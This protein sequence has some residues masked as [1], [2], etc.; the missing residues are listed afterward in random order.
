LA[1]QTGGALGITE[2]T[3]DFGYFDRAEMEGLDVW[4]HQLQL[5]EDAFSGNTGAFIR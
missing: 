3:T 5:I 4:E 1:E 2:E